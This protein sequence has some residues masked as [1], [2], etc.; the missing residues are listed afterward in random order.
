MKLDLIESNLCSS[1][2]RNPLYDEGDG[3]SPKSCFCDNCFYGRSEM[4]EEILRLMKKNGPLKEFKNPGRENNKRVQEAYGNLVA[5][6][7]EADDV[8]EEI[9]AG[10]IPH[11]IFC[12]VG[13]TD[14]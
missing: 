3:R 11:I 5:I 8:L 13:E 14:D 1:D 10:K 7:A 12:K 2:P 9:M 6:T 4:A